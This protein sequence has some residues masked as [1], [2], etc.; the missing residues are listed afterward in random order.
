RSLRLLLWLVSRPFSQT[1]RVRA[2][3][4]A[5]EPE[6]STGR[7]LFHVPFHRAAAVLVHERGAPLAGGAATRGAPDL[8]RAPR[9]RLPRESARLPEP[10]PPELSLGLHGDRGQV[11]DRIGA[12]R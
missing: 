8:V 5:A 4:P 10:A 2:P 9:R 7:V 1:R 3:S 11:G 6:R 12:P